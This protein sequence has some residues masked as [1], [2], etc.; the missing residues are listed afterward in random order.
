MLQKDHLY[1]RLKIEDL[2]KRF[3]LLALE[4][5]EAFEELGGKAFKA[6]VESLAELEELCAALEKQWERREQNN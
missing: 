1:F 5:K 4:L 3:E 6:K 2:K